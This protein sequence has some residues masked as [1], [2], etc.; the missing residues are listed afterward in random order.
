MMRLTV[1]LLACVAALAAGVALGRA[2]AATVF[3]AVDTQLCP[4]PLDVKIVTR[5]EPGQVET[6]ALRFTFAGPTTITLRNGATGRSAVL[7]STG[8]HTVDTRSGSVTF[9]G[10]HVWAWSTGNRVP[11]LQ[12]DGTGT[13]RAP[14]FV[15][16]P[17]S[18]TARV[19]DPCALVAKPPPSTRP[20]RTPAPWGLPAYALSRIASSGLKPLF[21]SVIR[22][23]HVHLDVI[24]DGRKVEI[25]AGVGMAEPADRG[26]CPSGLG[27]SGDCATGESFFG[28]VA[29][30]PLHTHSSSG[31]LHIE[32]DR[33][34]RFRL[35][36]F[37]DEWGVRFNARCIGGYCGAGELR[38]FV[39]GRRQ[40][41]DPRR[42]VL[43]NHQE[44]A[45]VFGRGHAPKRYRG[46]WPGAGC[47][48]SGEPSCGV[49]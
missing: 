33:Q 26:P 31:L 16:V 17:G 9:R 21:G 25:P 38:V 45:V 23:D 36:E 24:V 12:T 5:N 39:D 13:L 4:F 2:P 44:I 19:V 18:T 10:H 20:S 27:T 1:G 8:S 42:I 15:L 22:H 40:S 29:N 3:H 48:G 43:G 37:F 6:A 47:G 34:H 35:G 41:G 32:S 7:T 30:S 46:V 49:S 14:A 28:A 11:Y